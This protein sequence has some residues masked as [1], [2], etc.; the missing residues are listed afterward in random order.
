MDAKTLNIILDVVLVLAGIFM[1][2]SA[3]GIGG[4]VGRTLTYIVVGALIT[5]FAHALATW[6]PADMFAPY[7]GSA[8]RIVVLVGFL[9]LVYGFH[10]LRAMK[11]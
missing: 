1:V 5:G 3:R 8:H 7:N 11:R 6:T 2:Y 9:F 4:T 10:Q